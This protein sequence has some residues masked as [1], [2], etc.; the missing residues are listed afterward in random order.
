MINH[1]F[2]PSAQRENPINEG[3]ITLMGYSLGGKKKRRLN[4][5]TIY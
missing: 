2:E 3:R 5:D 4:E 1:V